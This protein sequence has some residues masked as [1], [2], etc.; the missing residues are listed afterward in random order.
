MYI[1]KGIIMRKIAI[2]TKHSAYNYGAMLQAYALQSTIEKLGGAPIIV[3]F[4]KQK[5]P[6][7][8]MQKS[9]SG[10]VKKIYS[11]RY[12][13]ELTE[14]YKRFEQFRDKS[15]YLSNAYKSYAE[16]KNNPP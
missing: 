13:K 12:K 6:G 4:G 14:G 7:V 10:L 2:V 5:R 1:K 16:L 3:D 9:F 8:K 11:I 15:L